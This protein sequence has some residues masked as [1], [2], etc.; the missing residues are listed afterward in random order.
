M[1]QD[2]EAKEVRERERDAER[3]MGNKTNHLAVPK[4]IQQLS[5]LLASFN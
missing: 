5:S 2:R 4:L 1:E 3:Y